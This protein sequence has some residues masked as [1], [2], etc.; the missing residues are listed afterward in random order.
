MDDDP[1]KDKD[2]GLPNI[3]SRKSR[4]YEEMHRSKEE[5]KKKSKPM[6]AGAGAP[7]P[8]PPGKKPLDFGPK[9][10]GSP[11]T[12]ESQHAP[13]LSKG[14]MSIHENS[15]FEWTDRRGQSDKY[16]KN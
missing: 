2:F 8:P 16:N 11:S 9:P 12:T 7:P 15:R 13:Y 3:D 10:K 14:R 1:R 5:P 4:G 6:T